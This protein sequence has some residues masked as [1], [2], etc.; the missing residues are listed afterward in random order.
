MILRF[1]T[2]SNL[3]PIGFTAGGGAIY[4]F[5]VCVAFEL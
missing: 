2:F 5:K 1:T 3:T 4:K